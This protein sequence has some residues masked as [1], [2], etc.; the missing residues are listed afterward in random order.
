MSVHNYSLINGNQGFVGLDNYT[1]ILFSDSM[2]NKS[3]ML[4]M[5]NTIIFVVLS[6]PPLVLVSLGLALLADRL[7]SNTRLNNILKVGQ[8]ILCHIRFQ[9]LLFQPFLCGC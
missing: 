2:Y 1:R 8:Y 7:P 4:G 5:K 3:F 9:L 6:V